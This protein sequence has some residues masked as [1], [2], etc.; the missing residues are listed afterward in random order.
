MNSPTDLRELLPE[1]R[2]GMP[3]A[4][5]GREKAAMST[6][7]PRAEIN[8][9]VT[10]VPILAL[11]MTPM[12]WVR[13]SRPAFTKLTTMTVVADDDWIRAVIK[14]PVR[15][16]VTLLVVMAVRILRK[17][18][19]ANFCRPSL[20]IFIPYRNKPKEPIRRRKSKNE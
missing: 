13:V 1:K 4:S 7:N 18:S 14:T 11:I 17:L 19:P 12:D 10:V 16:P 6:L 5:R 2:S 3:N 15:T 8:H 9:A 20:M